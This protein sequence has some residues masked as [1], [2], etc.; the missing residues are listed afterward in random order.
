MW[1][2]KKTKELSNQTFSPEKIWNKSHQNLST[3]L[4]TS[5]RLLPYTH[6]IVYPK[7]IG[8]GIQTTVKPN[9]LLSGMSV[10]RHGFYNSSMAYMNV[11]ST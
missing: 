4:F 9:E 11:L 3:K 1:K 7:Y 10:F 2:I 8:S 5:E 6:P